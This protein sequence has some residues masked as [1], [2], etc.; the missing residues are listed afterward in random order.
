MA[1]GRRTVRPECVWLRSVIMGTVDGVVRCRSGLFS[2]V[3][4]K[5]FDGC[6]C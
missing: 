1:E 5:A 6:W 4:P 3:D 2:G